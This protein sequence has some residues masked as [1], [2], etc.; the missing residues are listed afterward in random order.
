MAEHPAPRP[1]GRRTFGPVVLAGVAASALTAVAANQPWAEVAERTGAVEGAV[2]VASAAD[3]RMPLAGALS[4]VVLAAWGVLLVTRGVVRRAAAVGGLIA[5]VG[6]VATVVVG[7]GAT[8]DSLREAFAAVGAQDVGVRVTGWFW[9]AAVGAAFCVVGTAL[10]VRYVGSW[11]AM[12][13]RYDAPGGRRDPAGDGPAS[14][15]E[16]LWRSIDEGRD[17]TA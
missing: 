10:A 13:A 4:L 5:S 16:E 1:T 14:E 9:V 15:P 2:A 8:R 17:P 7:H 11:P 12:G 6:L 3:P